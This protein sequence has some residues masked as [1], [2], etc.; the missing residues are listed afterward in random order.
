VVLVLIFVSVV[1]SNPCEDCCESGSCELAFKN[2][3]GVCCGTSTKANV[4]KTYCCPQ[5]RT[6]E[7]M[8]DEEKS[9]YRCVAKGAHHKLAGCDACCSK[10]GNCEEAFEG[11]TGKCCGRTGSVP[12][13]CPSGA[14]CVA[15]GAAWACARSQSP[16]S[17]K[18]AETPPKASKH[19]ALIAGIVCAILV[20]LCIAA[21][22]YACS[23]QS[24]DGARTER[25]G[26]EVIPV[27]GR[28]SNVPA[29]EPTGK[30]PP[31]YGQSFAGSQPAHYSQPAGYPAYAPAYAPAYGQPPAQ[32]SSGY[33]G[34]AV[35]G[36]AGAG[37]LGGML[38]DNTIHRHQSHDTPTPASAPAAPAAPAPTFSADTSFGAPSS[39][40]SSDAYSGGD[41]G[42]DDGGNDFDASS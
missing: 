26:M 37:I 20:L 5:A 29:S 18:T 6:C 3:P 21:I 33:S 30:G 1:S 14:Q 19:G 22:C 8:G 2:R 13:C 42:G 27:G 36:A 32:Q 23:K 38:L 39:D 7:F 40:V 41:S 28:E 25:P 9:P 31:P 24:D 4:S 35:A 34:G 12:Y 15:S 16:T 17:A 11:Q 10:G